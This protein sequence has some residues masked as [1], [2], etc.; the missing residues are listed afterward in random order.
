MQVAFIPAIAEASC[1]SYRGATV[2]KRAGQQW[3]EPWPQV[4]ADGG[5]QP[6]FA[7]R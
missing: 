6:L 3:G 4:G 2:P 5:F 1:D 7:E